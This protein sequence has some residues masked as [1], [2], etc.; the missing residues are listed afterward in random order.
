[1]I[2]YY[3]FHT[4]AWYFNALKKIVSIFLVFLILFNTLGFYGLLEGLRYKSAL[5]LVQRLDNQQYSEEETLTIKVPLAIPYHSDTNDYER[6][7]G[8]V[9][10]KGEFYRLIKQKLERDTLSIVCIKDYAS[11]RIK[12]ALADYVKTFTDKPA[13]A[14]HSGKTSSNFIKD[15]LPS[16]ITISTVAEGWHYA[17]AFFPENC[18]LTNADHSITSPPPKIIYS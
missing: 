9:E 8:E 14:K 6:V 7:N 17:L 15:Y 1:L 3:F 13:D 4:Y 5:E 2:L 18:D 11:K 16:K 12:Q 10:Y